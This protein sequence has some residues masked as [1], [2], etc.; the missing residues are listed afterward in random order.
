MLIGF[1]MLTV[2][3]AFVLWV[4]ASIA[5]GFLNKRRHLPFALLA[6]G[7]LVAI[8]A[9]VFWSLGRIDLADRLGAAVLASVL[10]SLALFGPSILA[11]NKQT[12]G[13][14]SARVY[15]GACLSAMVVCLVWFETSI[16]S[17]GV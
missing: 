11:R 1:L 4:P 6:S 5:A 10:G 9:T 13:A 12:L 2:L 3:V 14:L 17:F 16:E 15:G 7:V 8:G